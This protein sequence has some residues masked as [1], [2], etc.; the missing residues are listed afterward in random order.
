[1]LEFFPVLGGGD[2]KISPPGDI[3]DHPL[4]EMS[5]IRSKFA[6]HVVLSPG[7][8]FLVTSLETESSNPPSPIAFLCVN[9]CKAQL[10]FTT[11]P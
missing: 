9:I 6:D 5:S 10:S 4:C 7:G 8:A 3:L 2:T 11:I 1:M